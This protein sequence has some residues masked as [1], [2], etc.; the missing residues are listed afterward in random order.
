MAVEA[1]RGPELD[2]TSY[3]KDPVGWVGDKLQE[4]LWSKQREIAE[5]VVIER[6]VV[7]PS[8]HDVGKSFLAARLS[9]WWID[10]H[11]PGTAFVV[12]TA[13]TWK[14]VRVVLWREINKAHA[15]GKLR[16][17]MN[18][19]E[20][21]LDRELVAFGQK[22]ADYDPTA[23][24]GIH[25]LYVLVIIDEGAG[26]PE[27]IYQAA[28]S[29][30]A[31]DNSRILAIGN[32]T[33]PTSYFSRICKPGSGWKVIRINGLDSPNFTNEEIPDGLGDYLLSRT[34]ERELREEEGEESVIYQVRILGQFPENA[35][36]GLVL[37]SWL[38]GC[39]HTDLKPIGSVELG[40]DVGAGGDETHL[41]ERRGPVAGRVWKGKTPNW[42]DAVAM[43]LQAIQESGATRIKID[44]IGIGWGV[45]GRLKEMYDAGEI[46]CEPVGVNV[47]AASNDPSKF[48]KLRSQ[49]WWDIARELSRTRGWDL[50]NV[51]EHVFGQLIAQKYHRDSSNRVLAEPKDQTRKAIGRS[52]DDADALILAYYDAPSKRKVKFY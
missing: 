14:Q 39:Q 15:K 41:R 12:T 2:G 31:N 18:Q 11:P 27:L 47:G 13:P 21:W 38:V 20:Y 24:Q 44:M 16:G 40:M 46:A 34:Y 36:D 28:A 29:L 5:A 35:S 8:G 19:T 43:A 33:D 42:S 51:D 7:V 48:I 49:L 32:P 22:P 4:H 52:P 26:V 9:M 25:A 37:Y 45:Y 10:S 30:A 1:E 3:V 6:R 50:T 17:R 23:F